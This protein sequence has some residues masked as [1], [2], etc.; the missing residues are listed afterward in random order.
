MSNYLKFFKVLGC[1]LLLSVPS[2]AQTNLVKAPGNIT[3]L[4][5]LGNKLNFNTINAFG[6]IT[7]YAPNVIRVRLDKKPLGRNFSYAVIAEPKQTKATI[8]QNE[9][10][11]TIITDSLQARSAKS[12]SPLV[13]TRRMV[14]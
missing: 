5:I 2:L 9:T 6:E 13:F 7:I 8:T 1:A 3:S 12:R 11:I 14:S 4:N 10:E